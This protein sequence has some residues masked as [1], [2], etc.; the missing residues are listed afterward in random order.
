MAGSRPQRKRLDVLL[1]ERGLA[2]SREKAQALILA[3]EV[4][5][6]GAVVD[7]ASTA[8]PVNALVESRRAQEPA[9]AS[10]GAHKLLHALERFSIGVEGRIAL[11]AGASTGGFTDVL[12]RH[13]VARVYA[14]DVGYGQ[15]LWRLRTDER[16]VVLERTNVRYLES[17]PETVDL[18]V[19]DLSFISLTLVLGRLRSLAAQSADFVLLVKPQF[20]AGR[21]EVGKSGVVR[22]PAVHRAVLLKVMEHA[23]GLGLYL[24]G[25]SASPVLGPAGNVEFLAWLRPDPPELVREQEVLI[26]E[27]ISE[28]EQVRA[29]RGMNV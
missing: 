13:G 22:D 9:Y 6:D 2:Q 17:L 25:L 8:V 11:D 23:A 5:V 21:E 18:V 1:V 7:K 10:R 24:H 27:A 14:V 4:R 20:E 15:L 3:G 19:G 26:A 12:L 16:V 28:A 29:S